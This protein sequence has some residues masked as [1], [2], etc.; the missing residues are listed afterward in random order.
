MRRATGRCPRPGPRAAEVRPIRPCGFAAA[1]SRRGFRVGI[2]KVMLQ[3]G[4]LLGTRRGHPWHFET[5]PTRS[6]RC[7]RALCLRSPRSLRSHSASPQAT[8]IFSVT[9]AV[10]LRPLP[11]RNPDRLVFA[12][13]D[14]SK[15]AVKDFPLSNEDFWTCAG[16]PRRFQD[17]SGQTQA[18]SCRSGKTGRPNSP[19]C[20]DHDQFLPHDGRQG[21]PGTRLRD[22]DGQPQPPPAPGPAAS[23]PAQ[24]PAMA[25]LSH[26]YWQRRFGGDPKML[27]QNLPGA[28]G[29]GTEIVGVLAPGFELLFPPDANT[30]RTAGHV[31]RHAPHLRQCQPQRRVA[32][33]R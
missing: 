17:W 14:M 24:L 7:A 1:K 29:R 22:S 3:I 31:V 2:L 5:W 28:G 4:Y 30:E 27:G 23:A 19:L 13:S 26:D 16:V 33:R 20:Q 10:L 12:I 9:N 18:V 32:A 15:R 25:I 6:A 11:Y 21:D 8:A